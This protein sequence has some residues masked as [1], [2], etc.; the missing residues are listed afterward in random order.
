VNALAHPQEFFGARTGGRVALASSLAPHTWFR[1]GG[2]A[3]ALVAP[4]SVDDLGAFLAALPAEMPVFVI[5]AGSNLIVRDG[6][7]AGAVIRLGKSFSAIAVDDDA[8]VVGGAAADPLVARRAAEAG[9]AGLEFL[10]GIPGT[11]GGA[12]AMNAGA[13]GGD[14]AAVLDWAEIVTRSGELVRLPAEAFAFGYRTAS[15]LPPESVVVRARLRGTR[16]EA[17]AIVARLAEIRR[18]RETTQPVRER[19]GGSTFRNPSPAESSLKAWELVDQAGCRGLVHEGAAVSA[20]HTNFLVNTGSATAAAIE[21]LGE[22]VRGRVRETSG[23]DLHWEIKR[24]G[25]PA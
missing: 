7:M 17:A 14:I 19:T 10:A 16:G 9:L 25:R 8:M 2:P 6:G 4:A 5:G 24:V 18:A 1:V 13:Y 3:E 22:I 21:A 23:V 12:I 11:I 20:L 15:G